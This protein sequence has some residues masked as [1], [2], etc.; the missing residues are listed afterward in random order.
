M[1]DLAP[2]PAAAPPATTLSVCV[3]CRQRVNAAPGYVEPGRPLLAAL[4]QRLADSGIVVRGVQCFA[5]C[6]RPCTIALQA[7]GKWNQI[8]GDLT[9]AGDVDA[10]VDAALIY[11]R[12]P[13]GIIPWAQTPMAFRRGGVA[14]LPPP[15]A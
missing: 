15:P 2:F 11:A 5:V 13:D 14:R 10:I 1:T 9:L 3:T 6:N 7:P 8:I 12:T 4:E